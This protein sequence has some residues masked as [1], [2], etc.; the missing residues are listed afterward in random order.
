MDFDTIRSRIASNSIKSVKEL[1][2]DMLLVANNASVFYSKNTR[3][4]KSAMLLRQIVTASLRK[5]FKEYGSRV[6][7]TTFTSSRP[8]H[9]PPAKPRSIRP[10]NRKPP[11]KA[12]NDGNAIVG[13]SQSSKK[14][15]K[16]DSPPSVESLPVTKKDSARPRK[17]SR[18]RASQKVESPSKGRKRT[19][20]R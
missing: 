8:M 12:S 5:H 6:P 2:R 1:F 19:R 13:N 14:T 7:I 9:K 18:G 16:A 10:G 3:E 4:Y 20:A 11:V 15:V 17:V